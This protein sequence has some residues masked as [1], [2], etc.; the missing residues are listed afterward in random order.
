MSEIAPF[1]GA[2]AALT[3]IVDSIPYVRDTVRRSTCPQRGTWLIWSV[4]AIVVCLSQR[5]V[6]ASLGGALAA[7]SVGALEASLLLYPV[8]YCLC[9]GGLALL[10]VERR[11]ALRGGERRQS[12]R[13]YSHVRPD[14][15]VAP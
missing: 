4:L 11:A 15:T 3:G 10:I 9:N 12:S 5:A 1:L 13:A 7:G 14:R 8:Y 2:L 6:G